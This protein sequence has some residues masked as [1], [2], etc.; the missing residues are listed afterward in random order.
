MYLF[1]FSEIGQGWIPV[2][3]NSETELE[4]ILENQRNL[5][6]NQSFWIAGSARTTGDIDFLHYFQYELDAGKIY[7]IVLLVIC[8]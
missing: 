8:C 7:E 1:M 3:L 5:S 6:N 4:F 2:V